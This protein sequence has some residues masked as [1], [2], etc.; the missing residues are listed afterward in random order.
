MEKIPTGVQGLDDVLGGGFPR[1]TTILVS[2]PS[3]TGKSILCMQFLYKGIQEHDENGIY[4]TLEARPKDLRTEMQSLGWDIQS[5][6]EQGKLAIMDSASVASKMYTG[7]KFAM[8]SRLD[9]DGLIS[10]I[11]GLTKK[12]NARRLVI[13]SLPA[14]ELRVTDTGLIRTIIYRLSS[15]LL[16][17]K[18]TSLLTTESVH[19]DMIS[20]YGVEEFVCR[21]VIMLDLEERGNDLKR[22]LRVRKMRE[23]NH[24]M[25]KINFEIGQDGITVFSRSQ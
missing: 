16:E 19:P 24:T 17:I 25:K 8:P 20:R 5:Y 6:E 11:H 14:L 18:V 21:G 10:K 13:D 23:I 2:G 7:E 1:S 3:G 15:L 22:V 12:I 9:V 4:V